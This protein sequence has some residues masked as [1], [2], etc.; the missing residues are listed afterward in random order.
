MQIAL[1][2][3]IP[4]EGHAR[5]LRGLDRDWSAD[6]D[7]SGER[8]GDCPFFY[9]GLAVCDDPAT[10]VWRF[11]T[12]AIYDTSQSADDTPKCFSETKRLAFKAATENAEERRCTKGEPSL[13][14]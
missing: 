5:E 1:D 3:Q 14:T 4:R 13:S 12:E 7:R 2:R 6:V 11:D 9:R 10:D 8:D